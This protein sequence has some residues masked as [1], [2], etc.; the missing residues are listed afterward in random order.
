MQET[1]NISSRLCVPTVASSHGSPTASSSETYTS[2]KGTASSISSSSTSSLTSKDNIAVLASPE[3][4]KQTSSQS[5]QKD[6]MDSECIK[7]TAA[8]HTS[9]PTGLVHPDTSTSNMPPSS[10][11]V[12]VMTSELD[13]SSQD[14]VSGSKKSSKSSSGYSTVETSGHKSDPSSTSSSAFDPSYSSRTS[15]IHQEKK[16]HDK[17]KH[18]TESSSQKHH[19]HT[20]DEKGKYKHKESE[21]DDLNSNLLN[22][23]TGV[24]GSLGKGHSDH[25]KQEEWKTAD[26]KRHRD[27]PKYEK[28]KTRHHGR[29]MERHGSSRKSRIRSDDK[30]PR[31]TKDDSSFRMH[32]EHKRESREEKSISSQQ[33]TGSHKTDEKH[34]HHSHIS[35]TESPDDY[36]SMSNRL[37]FRKLHHYGD[38]TRRIMS[39]L[40]KRLCN[41]QSHKSTKDGGMQT[42]AV[43]SRHNAWSDCSSTFTNRL[44]DT[45]DPLSMMNSARTERLERDITAS[46]PDVE[47]EH[48]SMKQLEKNNDKD[49]NELNSDQCSGMGEV[50]E[51]TTPQ[52]PL[53]RTLG[54]DKHSSVDETSLPSTSSGS[55]S[56]SHA[57]I[58]AGLMSDSSNSLSGVKDSKEQSGVSVTKAGPDEPISPT[59]KKRSRKTDEDEDDNFYEF[60]DAL[61]FGFDDFYY[62][63]SWNDDH[64]GKAGTKV[65]KK[66]T[67]EQTNEKELSKED[68][69]INQAGPVR[70]K[71]ILKDDN[72]SNEEVDHSRST[73]TEP[74]VTQNTPLSRSE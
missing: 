22:S 21:S 53:P 37:L 5:N 7:N 29:D 1:C 20:S 33:L 66:A 27:E 12:N 34:F 25:H 67:K 68:K 70:Y 43:G 39:I 28:S 15:H 2:E 30:H 59:K 35:Q 45:L 24:S 32:T 4:S 31:N 47:N 23:R 36:D 11:T 62:A 41:L 16:N 64:G 44:S 38:R 8:S 10:S 69:K 18:N 14:E 57:G 71:Q 54:S 61:G 72:D 40:E 42:E 51:E 58:A 52:F 9:L 74:R 13:C 6:S 49:K 65:E 48:L 60:D 19:R 55:A 26:K 50:E 46:L 56:L 63:I 3:A 17:H 73:L